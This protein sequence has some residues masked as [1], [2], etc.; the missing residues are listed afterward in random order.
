MFAD[1][2]THSTASDG[3]YAPAELVRLAKRAGI[4]VLALTDHD[5]IDGLPEAIRA[6]AECGV[7][8][9]RGVEWSA[10][11]YP[12]F[13]I[14]GY[15]F[16]P[17]SPALLELC[18]QMRHSREKRKSRI[19]EYLAEKGVPVTLEEVEE[20]G[21]AASRPH[22]ARAMIRRGYVSSV[23]EAFAR[24]LSTE[25][26]MRRAGRVKPSARA[27]IETVRAA[28]GVAALAHPYQ[29]GLSPEKLEALIE[30]LRGYGLNAMECFYPRHS[31][32]QTAFYRRLAARFGLYETGGSDFHGERVKP[33]IALTPLRLDLPWLKF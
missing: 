7:R 30:E 32:E 33:D 9:V 28:G 29:I 11:E 21:P 4:D 27:C 18:R 1:L 10:K 13:H 25:E 22:F 19:L 26:F 12:A 5:T 24:Y 2:H 17:D 16:A 14:L 8:I 3:Q 31:P 23:Q 6:G 20:F 15:A